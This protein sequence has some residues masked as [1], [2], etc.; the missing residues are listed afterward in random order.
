MTVTEFSCLWT[1]Q[2]SRYLL[3]HDPSTTSDTSEG[4]GCHLVQFCPC[5]V[6]ACLARRRLRTLSTVRRLVALVLTQFT[7]ENTR[8]TE[9]EECGK[10]V[11]FT[12]SLDKCLKHGSPITFL[13]FPRSNQYAGIV[14]SP[15]EILSPLLKLKLFR[16]HFCSCARL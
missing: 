1:S 8:S 14:R 12:N 13:I 3:L 5:L 11:K 6:T 4:E 16:S 7:C 9:A 2:R 10:T 15:T